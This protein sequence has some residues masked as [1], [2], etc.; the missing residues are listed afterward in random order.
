MKTEPIAR[1]SLSLLR[2][3]ECMGGGSTH[4]IWEIN[5]HPPQGGLDW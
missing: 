4:H 5:Q 2:V 1:N 3:G